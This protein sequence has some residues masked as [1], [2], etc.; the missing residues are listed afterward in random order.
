M[1]ER[2]EAP[3]KGTLYE[4]RPRYLQADIERIRIAVFSLRNTASTIPCPG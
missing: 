2:A 4:P 3:N 1:D